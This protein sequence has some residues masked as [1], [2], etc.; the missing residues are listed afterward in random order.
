MIKRRL[1][2]LTILL[3]VMIPGMIAQE[4]DYG[5]GYQTIMMTNPSYTG[6]EGDGI[7]RLSYLNYYPGMNFNLNSFFV[8][9][10]SYFPVLHGGA[11]FYIS[12]D[13]M[14]GIV[15][16]LRG[17]FAYSYHLQAGKNIYI[18]AGL[19]ASFFYRGFNTSGVI[20]P[21]QIDPLQGAILPS[22]ETLESRGHTAFDAGAGF[23]L[24]AGR[25]TA[26]LSVGHLTEPDLSGYGSSV[27]KMQRKITL[28]LEGTFFNESRMKIALRPMIYSMIQ[29]NYF[30]AGS[31]AAFET[32][33]FSVSSMLLI[34]SSK[35]IDLQTGISFNKGPFI[36]FYKYCFNLVSGN[37]LLPA[38]LFQHAG[39][40]L[41]LN[42]V[43]KR[44]T[45]KTINFP[46]L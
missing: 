35:D 27:E 13:Y 26:G 25:Y 44:K 40:A 3:L 38:S 22:A 16:D 23:L 41:S 5:P 42:Y 36:A 32:S 8:S 10:D 6:S 34:N 46:E 45:I 20:L 31:G 14:G 9:Y 15:N 39:V 1:F 19:G 43:D 2:T 33:F 12:N 37:S 4:T 24:I 18:N 30:Q 17:G 29:G 11:G 7:L 28:C 21:D